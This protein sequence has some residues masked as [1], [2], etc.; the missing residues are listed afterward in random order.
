MKQNVDEK[1]KI[2]EAAAKIVLLWKADKKQN[3]HT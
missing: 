2:N 3:K 1:K